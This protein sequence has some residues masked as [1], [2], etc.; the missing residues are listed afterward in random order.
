V[1]YVTLKR[2]CPA[3]PGSQIQ[4]QTSCRDR[5][6]TQSVPRR[7]YTRRPNILPRDS[8]AITPPRLGLPKIDVECAG[9]AKPECSPGNVR[10]LRKE[11]VS[12]FQFGHNIGML[13]DFL[14]L[15]AFAVNHLNHANEARRQ[16]LKSDY[17]VARVHV[18]LKLIRYH[19]TLH[20][21]SLRF[22]SLRVCV[23]P[24]MGHD[25]GAIVRAGSNFRLV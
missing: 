13:L 19:A 6:R 8:Y 21:H 1:L 20:V 24:H 9:M 22:R 3:K 11:Y 7:S 4:V 25:P 14:M 17:R 18:A 5:R 12:L 23:L 10:L 16:A 2:E 15:N